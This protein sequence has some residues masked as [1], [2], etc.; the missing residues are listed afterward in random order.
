MA[1]TY[2]ITPQHA[3]AQ[4]AT[5]G[6]TPLAIST[7]CVQLYAGD[8]G[9]DGMSNPSDVATR[10]QVSMSDP[11]NGATSLDGGSPSWTMT[12]PETIEAGALWNGFDGND[13][14][15]AMYTASA[16]PP[17]DVAEGDQLI[18]NSFTITTQGMAS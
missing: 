4:L 5:L 7:V 11:V 15:Y 16:D 8:P 3:N 17:V 1:N 2:G 10:Q 18:L 9:V 12:G 14:A 13:S 6:N